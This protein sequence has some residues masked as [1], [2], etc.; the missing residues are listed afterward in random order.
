MQISHKALGKDRIPAGFS[1]NKEE[2]PQQ[3]HCT[4]SCVRY[5]T[6]SK[7]LVVGGIV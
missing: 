3:K 1:K 7:C 4:S 5:G 6:K 2:N